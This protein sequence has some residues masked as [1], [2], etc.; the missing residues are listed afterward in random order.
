M[1]IV[2]RRDDEQLCPFWS[3]AFCLGTVV[4]R[5]HGLYP[6]MSTSASDQ[7]SG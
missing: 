2:L 6:D 1:N 4:L 7:A 3:N 5:R